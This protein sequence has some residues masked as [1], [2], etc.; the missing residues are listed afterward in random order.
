MLPPGCE[1]LT[2]V[3]S[4]WAIRMNR[5]FMGSYIARPAARIF[6]KTG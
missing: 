4:K 3:V 2:S 1:S 6:L 5:Y